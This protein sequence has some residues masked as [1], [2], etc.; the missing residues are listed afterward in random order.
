V[1]AEKYREIF[2]EAVSFL[3]GNYEKIVADLTEKMNYASENLAF[4]AAAA[5]RD[6]IRAVKKL[7]EK[8]KV[9]ASPD[10]ERDI[11]AWHVGEPIS[12]ICIF[13]IRFGKLIDS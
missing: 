11:I 9:V 2:D 5:Y 1:S 10:T 3:S 13:Y 4:E 6:R 12:S 8:Q 7:E